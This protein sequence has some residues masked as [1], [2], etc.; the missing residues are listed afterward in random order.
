[1]KIMGIRPNGLA[2]CTM[3]IKHPPSN[4]EMNTMMDINPLLDIE[5]QLFTKLSSVISMLRPTY[6]VIH[7]CYVSYRSKEIFV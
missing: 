5:V 4:S 7:N 6:C 2:I 1:M 3:A